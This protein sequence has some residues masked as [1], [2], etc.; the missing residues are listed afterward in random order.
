MARTL[1]QITEAHLGQQQ[2]FAIQL[3]YQIEQLE[4]QVRELTARLP[5]PK[6]AKAVTEPRDGQ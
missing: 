5:K 6:P 2:F 4:L 3:A 1:Q